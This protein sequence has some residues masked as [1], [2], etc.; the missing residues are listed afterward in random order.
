MDIDDKF[1]DVPFDRQPEFTFGDMGA[2]L[3][4]DF[5]EYESAVPVLTDAQI[6]AAIEQG[7]AEQS[8]LDWLVTRIFDQGREGACVSDA[9]GGAN[10]LAQGKQF[11]KENVIHVSAMSLYKRI[12]RTA[13]SGAMVSD[14]LEEMTSR[15]MLPLDTPENRSRFG[16]AVM[17]NTG[18]KNPFP[19]DW[20]G[21]A[22]KFASVEYHV[23]KTVNGLMTALCNRDPVIVGRE[24][25]S[26]CYVKPVIYK[27]SWA[28][29]YV[30]S[31]GK[32]GM[33]MGDFDHGF[34]IDTL[35]QIKKSAQ[36][37]FVLRSVTNP[38]MA[39]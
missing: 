11:G 14:G 6:N 9:C 13:S 34:G 38:N 16:D 1:I 33:G 18:F 31:W 20:E 26:I 19:D 29:G 4:G 12:G 21:T 5:S 2:P 8:F 35:S 37:A 30:N 24:G 32:W 3:F 23:V 28:V 10:E 27:G 17:P 22:I 7:E 25:H 15:G 36:Y 39:T